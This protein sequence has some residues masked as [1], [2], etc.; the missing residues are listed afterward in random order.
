MSMWSGV[1][2]GRVILDRTQQTPEAQ[3]GKKQVKEVM[4]RLADVVYPEPPT[5]GLSAVVS[6][7]GVLL[8][9]MKDPLAEVVNISAV[10]HALVQMNLADPEV[11]QIV[12]RYEGR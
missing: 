9:D 5:V 10:L 6:Y 7:L 8:A 12:Y 3:K 2:Q 1:Q 4:N 11:P